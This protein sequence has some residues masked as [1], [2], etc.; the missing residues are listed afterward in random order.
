VLSL[1]IVSDGCSIEDCMDNFF[2]INKV[3]GYQL[4]GKT[5]KAHQK[6]LFEKLPNVL[7]INLKRFVYTDRLIKKKE[8]VYFGDIL[9]IEDHHVSPQLQLG[10]FKKASS[11]GSKRKYRLFSVVEHIG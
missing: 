5:V 10:V 3:E 4:N 7:I 11:A 9:T 2:K 6:L 8:H 1:D